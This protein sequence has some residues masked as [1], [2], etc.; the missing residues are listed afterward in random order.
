MLVRSVI[1]FFGFFLAGCSGQVSKN[2]DFNASSDKALVLLGYEKTGGLEPELSFY[3]YETDSGNVI[4]SKNY[5]VSIGT[6]LLG[7]PKAKG[8]YILAFSVD[9]GALFLKQKS[10]TIGYNTYVTI[11]NSNTIA[12][13]AQA[14]EVIYLG[15]FTV[16]ETSDYV[17]L[18]AG[19]EFLSLDV[20]AA[21]LKLSEF[22]NVTAELKIV[23][24]YLVSFSCDQNRKNFLGV[25]SK[26]C[27]PLK[28]TESN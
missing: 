15:N 26:G 23:E 7:V 28:V 6:N 21:N 14:G 1:L 12:F 25:R 10:D 8:T 13:N 2:I 16:N 11:F 3:A 27:R 22:K 19:I 9:P 18:G 20:E 4:A 24:P 5:S 17:P